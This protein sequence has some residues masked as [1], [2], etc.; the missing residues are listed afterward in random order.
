M[1]AHGHE[2]RVQISVSLVRT[3]DGRPRYFVAQ[4]EDVTQQRDAEAALRRETERLKLLQTVAEA[5]NT[6]D[7]ADVAYARALA[8]VCEHTGWPIGHVYRRERDTALLVPSDLWYFAPGADGRFDEFRRATALTAWAAGV[9]LPG[10]VMASGAPTWLGCDELGDPRRRAAR[11]AG[12]RG[13]VALPVPAGSEVVAVLEFFTETD[14]PPDGALLELLGDVGTQLGRAAERAVARAQAI[15]LDDA[16]ARF[17]ANA[18]HE[19]RTPLATLRTVAGLLGSRRAQMTDDEIAECCELLERQGSNLDTLVDDLL[20]L[21]RLQQG[22]DDVDV[23]LLDVEHWVTRALETARPPDGVAVSAHVEA[24][25]VVLGPRERLHRALVN[26]L[27]NAYR[28]GGPTV[29]VRAWRDGADVVVAVE[30]DG[31]GVP[32][33]LLSGLFEPFTR[34]GA[35]SGAGLGLAITR[36]LVEQAGGSVAYQGATDQG[37][38]FVLRL[39]HAR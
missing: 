30:D 32:R 29:D 1:H 37:A 26:L 4:L 36:A 34:H 33:E 18:A 19:L 27:T 10:R 3:L 17:V 22:H 31:D 24:G 38:R 2:I 6:A 14:T 5:A 7:E 28:H 25:L 12:L 8:A 39:E 21:S 15:A 16:R 13:G 35:G 23:E 9:G 20:D 11:D